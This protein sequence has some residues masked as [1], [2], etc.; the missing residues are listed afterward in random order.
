MIIFKNTLNFAS[1]FAALALAAEIPAAL[2]A[3]V[4]PLTP[5]IAGQPAKPI[6]T[7][8]ARLFFL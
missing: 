5:L 3:P 2:A 1:L 7:C 4:G 6:R 8:F